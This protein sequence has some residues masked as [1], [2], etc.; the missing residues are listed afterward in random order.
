MAAPRARVCVRAR[1]CVTAP[2]QQEAFL[3]PTHLHH[4]MLC[5]IMWLFHR[6]TWRTLISICLRDV[7]VLL[8]KQVTRLGSL[9]SDNHLETDTEFC[10][11]PRLAAA[12]EGRAQAYLQPPASPSVRR[13]RR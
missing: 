9:P 3:S 2:H 8:T 11:A 4:Q 12:F 1:M 10:C 13:Q 7:L 6:T 5:S